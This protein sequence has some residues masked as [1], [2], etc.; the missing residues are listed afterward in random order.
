MLY[1]ILIASPKSI[2]TPYMPVIN[3]RNDHLRR[4]VCP[5][6]RRIFFTFLCLFLLFRSV[7]RYRH[8]GDETQNRQKR[9]CPF[10]NFFYFFLNF[11]FHILPH[12]CAALLRKAI[13]GLQACGCSAD[14][15]LQRK[16]LKIFPSSLHAEAFSPCI[17]SQLI[18]KKPVHG[19]STDR[20]PVHN[21]FFLQLDFL[22]GKCIKYTTP[23]Y[24]LSNNL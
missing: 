7:Y 21:S 15:N 11:I 22:S 5:K 13:Y 14:T 6:G 8:P 18:A 12:F 2:R 1:R 17:I 9:N 3:I 24:A 20:S 19:N 10:Y 4:L 23:L 16:D